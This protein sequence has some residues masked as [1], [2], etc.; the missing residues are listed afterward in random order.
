MTWVAA[1]MRNLLP[2]DRHL[3]R[4]ERLRGVLADAEDRVPGPGPCRQG[5]LQTGLAAVLAVVVGLGD[6]GDPRPLERLE[7]RADGAKKS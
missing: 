6:Q 5:H 3:V 1:M 2:V 7:G 4:G